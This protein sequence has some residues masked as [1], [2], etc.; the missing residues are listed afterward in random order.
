MQP[1]LF[2]YAYVD[3]MMKVINGQ[4]EPDTHS[5]V[6][7]YNLYMDYYSMK[8]KDYEG[9]FNTQYKPDKPLDIGAELA[10]KGIK[11]QK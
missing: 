3:T 5:Q 4:I 7:A 10:K 1:Q 8:V 9:W 11:I 2:A 6:E